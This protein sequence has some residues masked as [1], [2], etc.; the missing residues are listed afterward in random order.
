MPDTPVRADWKK[1]DR[2]LR[3]LGRARAAHDHEEGRWLLAARRARVH[4]HLGLGSFAEYVDR[5]LGYD[6]RAM[7]ER[8]RVAEMLERLPALSNALASGSIVWSAAREIS[9]VATAETEVAWLEA[10]NGRTVRDIEAMVA[11]RRPGDL[12]TTP[13]DP[14]LS[15]RVLRF[16]MRPEAVALFLEAVSRLRR[17]VDASLTEE[18]AL[19]EMAR[20][21]LGPAGSTDRAPFQVALTVC[22]RCDRAFQNG[23]GDDIEVGPEIAEQA[24]CDAQ[25]IGRVDGNGTAG[26]VPRAT[27]TIPPA[28][29]RA[30]VRRDHGRCVVPGCRNSIWVEVHHI[31]PRNEGGG[32][33][34]NGL[35][36]LCGTHHR[37]LHRG[38][39]WIEGTVSSGLSFRHA[40]GSLYGELPSAAVVESTVRAFAALR[41]Q[42]LGETAAR[43]AV[44]RAGLDGAGEEGTAT[45]RR[46]TALGRSLVLREPLAAYSTRTHVGALARL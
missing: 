42:G 25:L 29:R 41:G 46:R 2:T 34:P 22:E 31:T 37:M 43:L 11:G 16:E 27:Q 1:I 30:V 9:R 17:D 38:Y 36:L 24:S 28:V 3:R 19:V 39:L 23:R 33:E 45:V 12:P 8:L 26:G 35:V 13:A 5:I 7:I 14:A 20:R 21:V 6:A 4:L 10:T 40:D 18:E 15:K 44:A 32:H